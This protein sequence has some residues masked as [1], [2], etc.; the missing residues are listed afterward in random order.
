MKNRSHSTLVSLGAVIAL[1]P[2]G[3]VAQVPAV[4]YW[5]TMFAAPAHTTQ[6]SPKSID[7]PG[8]IAQV[9]TSNSTEYALLTNGQV[10]AWGLGGAGQLGD[11]GTA[12]SVNVPVQVQFPTGVTIAALATDA[13]PYNAA[14]AIDTSGNA[15]G[16][17]NDLTGAL[18][19]GTGV[20]QYLTPV[21]L[22]LAD[23]TLV[24]GASA[25]SLFDSDGSLYACGSNPFGQLGTGNSGRANTP[26]AVVGMQNQD[27]TAVVASSGNSGV[28]LATGDYYDWGYDAQGQLGDGIT[29]VSV[30]A[31][32][33]VSLPLP[34][35]QVV[36]GGD[37]LGNA[38]TLVELSDGSY[39]SWG[40]D[41]YGQL[42]DGKTTNEPSPIEF[43]PPTG[44]TYQLLA[45][46][47]ATSYGVTA[48]GAV[49]SWGE[50][51]RGQIGNGATKNE[52]EPVL[53]VSGGVTMISS[54]AEDVA[55]V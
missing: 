9:G 35:T 22:P 28:L 50:G 14:L 45:C 3:A 49:Y 23:V 1:T 51:N 42:G 55:T 29:G 36:A 7:L 40:D 54:T 41:K 8:P 24:A 11:G 44:V 30:N 12:N 31:P 18:C 52:L 16:W 13:M 2:I 48:A 15:W 4:T 19:L 47:G 5:G 27:I 46:G 38:S 32:V 34:V 10:W 6:K 17:G 20:S 53:V 25:H 21:E 37:N 33:E 39:R 43:F 26:V